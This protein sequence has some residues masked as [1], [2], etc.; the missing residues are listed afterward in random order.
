MKPL[1]SLVPMAHVAS[2]PHSIEFYKKLGFEVG[3]TFTPSDQKEPSW[4]WLR[5]GGAHLMV[6]RASESVD[7]RAQAVLFYIYC[8]DVP[9]F[10]GELQKN[11]V[12]VGEIEYPFYAP[13]G[14]FRVT[15]PDGYCL[16]ITHAG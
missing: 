12:M 7:A 14:E 16:M 10:R 1:H 11:G 15:D 2:V 4:A 9:T 8:E 13:R 6:T 5:S 3:N